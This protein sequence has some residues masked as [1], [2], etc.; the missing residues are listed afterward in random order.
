LP[1]DPNY[2]ADRLNFMLGDAQ[3]ALVFVQRGRAAKL[4]QYPGEI[5]FLEDDSAAESDANPTNR[6]E[7]ENLAYV[8]YTSGSAGRPKG[9]MNA[10]CGICNW[11]LWLRENYRTNNPERPIR[12]STIGKRIRLALD[13][14]SGLPPIEKPRYIARRIATRLKWE[15][16]KVQKAGYNLLELLYKTRKPDGENTDGGLLPLK[17]PVWIT[18]E[19]VTAKYKPRAYPGR[20]VFFRARSAKRLNAPTTAAG[21]RS[22][23]AASK[24]TTFQV[25][26]RRFLNSAM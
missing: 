8:I 1:L 18:L 6:T 14:C 7:P 17:L 25:N 5:V 21:P 24:F 13:E 22:R 10:H 3:P 16:G 20:I 19:R 12:H 4:P 26:M 15:A 2:P 23:K 9:V 11:L